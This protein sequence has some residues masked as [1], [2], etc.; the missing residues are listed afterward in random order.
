MASPST[1]GA[2]RRVFQ[3]LLNDPPL[4]FF[5]RTNDDGSDDDHKEDHH[6]GKDPLGDGVD[7]E[8]KQ[9]LSTS[10]AHEDGDRRSVFGV[11]GRRRSFSF[12][13]GH[14]MHKAAH[15]LTLMRTGAG[16]FLVRLAHL[17]DADE[18]SSIDS[19]TVKEDLE[20]LLSGSLPCK[21]RAAREMSL[22]GNRLKEESD[23][24]RL[25]FERGCTLLAGDCVDED[26][27]AGEI[28]SVA[29][30][31]ER[32]SSQWAVELKPMQVRTFEVEC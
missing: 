17:V 32:A 16:R 18:V 14:V 6:Q 29:E 4:L 30:K 22:S 8:K 11:D 19:L 13:N 23:S 12:T 20:K 31:E 10:P 15:L 21:P 25:V 9:A 3:Q 27:G 26:D 28:G 2:P 7:E 24:R 5:G 1:A